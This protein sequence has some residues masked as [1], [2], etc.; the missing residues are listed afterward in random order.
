MRVGEFGR[1]GGG[2]VLSLKISR[3][4][5]KTGLHVLVWWICEILR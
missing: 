3:R 4:N 1:E 2:A 5:R